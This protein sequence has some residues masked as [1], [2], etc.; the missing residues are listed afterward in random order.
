MQFIQ[1]IPNG[2]EFDEIHLPYQEMKNNSHL[3]IP[4][5]DLQSEVMDTYPERYL[6]LSSR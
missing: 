1:L 4:Q 2:P 3:L 5:S 6:L